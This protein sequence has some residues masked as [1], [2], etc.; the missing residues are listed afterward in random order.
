MTQSKTHFV[1]IGG[2]GMSALA[3]FEALGGGAVTGSDRNFDRG[4]QLDLKRRFSDLGI[5]LFAQDGSGIDAA[6]D[7]VVVSGAIEGDNPELA[8]AAEFKVRVEHRA[9]ALAAHVAGHKTVAVAGTSGKSTVTAMVFEILTA[10]GKSPS[11]ITG[12]P[13]VTLENKGLIG[14]AFRGKSD[15]L[16]IE[17]DESDGT[18]PKY[19]PHIGV[20][21]NLGKDHK[22]ISELREIF[23]KFKGRSAQFVVNADQENLAEFCGDALTFGFET[24]NI[25][26]RNLELFPDRC[27]FTVEDAEFD[28]PVPGRHNAENA[29]AATAAAVAAGATAAE[30]A[31]ALSIFRGVYRR[32]Q[33]VGE[34]RGVSVVDDYAHNP[35]KVSA[36][37]AAAHLRSKRVLA[38]FQP[39]GYGP[40]RF[41]KTEFID[42]FS[43]ALGPEDVLWMPEIYYAGGTATKDISA[44]N[45]V[46]GVSAAGRDA[47]FVAERSAICEKIASE[48]RAGDLVL[49]M[50]ARDPS[51]SDFAKSVLAGLVG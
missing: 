8:Q 29:L 33:S 12:A 50:G 42:A 17:A 26:G 18:L 34:A 1:G 16:V 30:A 38:V 25:R 13:L 46:E 20:L 39:H 28:V 21:L 5:R 19:A 35:D 10:S 24:G 4:L 23:D 14:N 11:L 43:R 45:L 49:V 9:D 48:A 7:K 47:R 15:F 32:F 41:L 22:E 31:A 44:E 27:R 37:M 51:L 3:Q 2:A 36:A 6:T 40:T